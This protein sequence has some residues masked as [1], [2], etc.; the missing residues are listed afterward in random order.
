MASDDGSVTD[1]AVILAPLSKDQ[2][3]FLIAKL[4]ANH[5]DLGDEVLNNVIFHSERPFDE[6]NFAGC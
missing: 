2:L 4:V 3:E 6:G 5:E 1:L